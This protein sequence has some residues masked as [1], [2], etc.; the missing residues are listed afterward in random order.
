MTDY[1]IEAV[2]H[3]I[4][5]RLTLHDTDITLGGV[6]R[7]AKEI[8]TMLTAAPEPVSDP[9]DPR[10]DMD[11]DRHYLSGL[12]AGFNMGQHDK[13]DEYEK[14]VASLSSQISE[15]RMELR[16]QPLSNTQELGGGELIAELRK[17]PRCHC[18]GDDWPSLYDR[19][20]DA[21]EAQALAQIKG[22]A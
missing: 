7:V 18:A 11:S 16:S 6:D 20:A 10:E 2:R 17:I 21:L 15:A 22:G 5:S 13:H 3:L 9:S 19:A 1:N 12:R 14:A 4:T 8:V